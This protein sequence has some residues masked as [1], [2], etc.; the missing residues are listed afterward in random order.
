MNDLIPYITALR[1]HWI[2]PWW[3]HSVFVWT[4]LVWR[5]PSA[6][7]WRPLPSSHMLLLPP[8]SPSSTFQLTP[9]CS[10]HCEAK[11]LASK[12]TVPLA[13]CGGHLGTVTHLCWLS[14]A[15]T[16]S[17]SAPLHSHR[18]RKWSCR[19]L[20]PQCLRPAI[21]SP[22]SDSVNQPRRSATRCLIA[23][24]RAKLTICYTDF[25]LAIGHSDEKLHLTL[26]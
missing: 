14:W 24:R 8:P 2:Q 20:L 13:V 17:Y 9:N 12:C 1:Q 3:N 23:K 11:Q 21:S 5:F 26:F 18:V 10:R 15:A 16:T 6:V 19:C 4:V 7:W 25:M 22:V